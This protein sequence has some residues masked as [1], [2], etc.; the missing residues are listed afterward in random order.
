MTK[1]IRKESLVRQIQVCFDSKLA[2]GESK[3]AVK[4]AENKLKREMQMAGASPEEIKAELYKHPEFSHAKIYSWETYR[5]YMKHANYFAKYCK[6][7]HGCKTLDECRPYVDEWL[8][9]RSDLSAY[10]LKLESAALAKLYD[11]STEEF[12]PT[13]SRDRHEIK[14]SRG[15]AARD[16]GFSLTKNADLIEFCRSTGLRR[17]ELQQL[18]GD[19]LIEDAEGNLFIH[20]TKASKGGRER[21]SPVV[22]N[23]ELVKRMMNEAGSEKV[24]PRI[25]SKA[26]IH[27][28]RAEYATE[29][30]EKY[31]RPIDEI[32]YD[33]VNK[34]TGRKYQSEVYYCRNDRAGIRLDKVAMLKAS[35]AL[36]HNRISVVGEHY[37]HVKGLEND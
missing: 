10:T 1:R 16:K 35:Q 28:Y 30:Y 4:S 7:T 2:I 17:A 22:H 37:L 11:V 29:I 25:H 36:G 31:A 5:S 15:T 12:L 33:R 19:M 20:V 27:G 9:S 3:H 24:F 32:P 34:G 21:M 23:P 14:R 18:R 8:Q 26:D 13:R 6:E